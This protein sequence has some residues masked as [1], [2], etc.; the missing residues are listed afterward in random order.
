MSAPLTCNNTEF[1]VNSTSLS[2]KSASFLVRKRLRSV[3]GFRMARCARR[4]RSG[5]SFSSTMMPPNGSVLAGWPNGLPSLS[6]MIFNETENFL[7]PLV[8]L[9]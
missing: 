3:L 4:I 8:R 2:G 9:S 6:N 1:F 5:T 7:L